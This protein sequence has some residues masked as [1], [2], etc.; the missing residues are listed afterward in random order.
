MIYEVGALLAASGVETRLAGARRVVTRDGEYGVVARLDGGDTASVTVGIVFAD[1]VATELLAFAWRSATAAK[2]HATAEALVDS[3]PIAAPIRRRRFAYAPPEGWRGVARELGAT[4]LAPGFPRRPGMITVAPARPISSDDTRDAVAALVYE[5]ASA[6]LTDHR[7][8]VEDL[9]T[10]NG[11]RG[12]T[13]MLTDRER[14]QYTAFLSD[15]TYLYQIRLE[16][17]APH[18]QRDEAVWRHLLDSIE[19]LPLPATPK[20]VG[21]AVHEALLHWAL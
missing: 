7:T 16:T 9:D 2:I 19:P 3:L 20:P 11:L 8:W 14:I 12:A 4:W 15:E 21:R 6:P 18:F 5:H 10:E 13:L 17:A 1:D